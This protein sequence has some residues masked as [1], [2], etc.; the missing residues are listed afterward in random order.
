MMPD[1][2][3]EM[4]QPRAEEIEAEWRAQVEKFRESGLDPTHLDTH[5]HVHKHAKAFIAYCRIAEA[6]GVPARSC[7]P[8]MTRRLRAA[9]VCC[10]DAFVDGWTGRRCTTEDLLARVEAAF[11]RSDQ[12]ETVELMCH[13]GYY[14]AE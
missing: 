8:V 4:Q 9:G 10:A 14:D 11:E 5:H 12:A 2:S 7:G 1:R 6:Y 3:V 13:P